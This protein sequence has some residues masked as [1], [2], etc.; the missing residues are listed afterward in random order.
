MVK[1]IVQAQ[2]DKQKAE[3][4]ITQ[5]L[6]GVSA[7]VLNATVAICEP[8]TGTLDV[9]TCLEGATQKLVE[10]T[11]KVCADL[12]DFQGEISPN[13][14]ASATDTLLCVIPSCFICM[15]AWLHKI[16]PAKSKNKNKNKSSQDASQTAQLG[17]LKLWHGCLATALSSIATKIKDLKTAIQPE[18]VTFED[19]FQ[20]TGMRQ[21]LLGYLESCDAL[22]ALAKSHI[23]TLRSLKL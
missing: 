16:K 23:S 4:L 6:D 9:A 8:D 5:G 11:D 19:G 21:I 13:L 17:S 12:A 14:F 2:M 15:Q 22:E 18:S 1:T 3:S 20:Q 10:S 7:H